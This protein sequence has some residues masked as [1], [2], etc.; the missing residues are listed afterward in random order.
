MTKEELIERLKS[1]EWVD[2]EV[3][4][5]S[6]NLPKSVWETVS[7]FSNTQGGWI[8]LGIKEK[9][10]NGVST[11]EIQGVKNPEKIEQDF[12]CT[13]RSEKFNTLIS[14]DVK[15]YQ[16]GDATVL[17][18]Y[19]PSSSFKPVFFNTPKNTFLRKGS[20][21]H[22]ATDL[23]FGIIQREQEFGRKSEKAV[24]NTSLED[25][26]PNSLNSYRNT[27]R[28]ENAQY[29][30]NNLSDEEFCKKIGILTADG[31][32]TVGGL[33]MFGKLDSIHKLTFNFWIDY[34]EIPGTSVSNAE[35]RYTFRLQEQENIWESYNII[36]QRLRNFVDNP[37]SPR[38][39]GFAPDD[40]SRL[41]CLREALVNLCAHADYFDSAHPTIRVYTDH[42]SFQNPGSFHFDVADVKNQPIASHPRNP[43]ILKFFRLAKLSE[44]AGYGIEKILNWTELT[45]QEVEFKS[46][47][48]ISEVIFWQKRG[49]GTVNGT[50]N[51]TVK[52][53]QKEKEIIQYI[54]VNP[55]AK[56]AT[57]AEST[58][59]S[60]RTLAR[61]ISKW[62]KANIIERIGSDKAG[63]WKVNIE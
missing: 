33:F 5:A 40:E 58:N 43:N 56:R 22:R 42:I 61:Y 41:Y 1:P 30:Y 46:Y 9:K 55:L 38:P 31:E 63:S 44:N 20:G 28:F 50:V 24:P 15:K 14:V 32:V 2:F 37:Y 19:I 29:S 45:G 18:F 16:F 47:S 17:A 11:Y 34:I 60:L 23:E 21:D 53:S 6:E 8:I 3:K 27:L 10:E 54:K 7:A 62:Q 51:G 48:S 49:S 4:E 25:I 12:I 36:I 59:T 13:L 57:I 26:Y 52:L 39:D 35:K